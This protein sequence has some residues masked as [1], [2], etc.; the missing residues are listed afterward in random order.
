MNNPTGN[1]SGQSSFT[2]NNTYGVSRR[3]NNSAQGNYFVKIASSSHN[4]GT[5]VSDFRVRPLNKMSL[6]YICNPTPVDSV[7][8]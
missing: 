4:Q 6:T 8:V 7:P 5:N 3:N 2:A 1:S